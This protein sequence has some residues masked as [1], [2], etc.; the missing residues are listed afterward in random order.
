M[1]RD[2][3]LKW[4]I[5]GVGGLAV[6]ALLAKHFLPSLPPYLANLRLRA[7]EGTLAE[8][9][10][11]KRLLVVAPH[12]DDETLGPGGLIQRAVRHG[13]EVFVALM[14]NGDGWQ[15][16]RA[17]AF[18]GDVVYGAAKEH[19]RLG[20]ERQAESL[21]V[22]AAQGVP[23][24]HVIFLGYPDGGV[25]F[26]WQPPHWSFA[27]PL[28]APHTATTRNPYANSLTPNGVYC[29]AQVLADMMAVLARAQPTAVLTTPPFDVQ[30]EH[31]A[32]YDFV[33][34]A[35]SEYERMTAREVPIYCFLIHRNDWPAPPGR[36][37]DLPFKPPA[38]WVKMPG[39]EWL[40]F[41]LSP[42]EEGL[43]ERYLGYYRTQNAE[44]SAELQS[45]VRTN[46][47]FARCWEGLTEDEDAV[48]E[49]PVG[50]LPP[51]RLRPSEDIARVALAADADG[52]TVSLELAGRPDPALRYAVIW[53]EL[54]DTAHHCGAL[55]WH[56]GRA[57]ILLSSANGTM[58]EVPVTGS[59]SGKALEGLV[60]RR[61]FHAP[62][63]LFEGFS[64]GNKARYLNHSA[65]E[66]YRVEAF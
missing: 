45:F 51:D 12:P 23:R 8:A 11:G 6:V 53:H 15:A 62:T 32:T 20:R 65:V 27:Q 5:A 14:T 17:E 2:R 31:W 55:V 35:V 41:P 48:I 47:L 58:H 29:G 9:D 57:V 16:D 49:D 34:L 7:S 43:K 63:A 13:T 1:M 36:H 54:E 50:D 60:D 22:L 56:K 10:L 52:V 44:R 39:V 30:R 18:A 38:A 40:A 21:R 24:D 3:R 4:V 66:W 64:Q 37:L 46:E 33:R 59:S 26:M 25:H 42:A 61:L 19:L 28:R